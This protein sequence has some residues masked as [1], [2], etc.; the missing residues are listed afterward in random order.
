MIHLQTALCPQPCS[1]PSQ[2]YRRHIIQDQ[3]IP[4]QPAT[5]RQN[6]PA[7]PSTQHHPHISACRDTP[8]PF[9]PAVL[10]NRHQAT[11]LYDSG[12][13]GHLPHTPTHPPVHRN[14]PTTT[15]S[16][17]LRMLHRRLTHSFDA[18]ISRVRLLCYIAQP[19]P[20]QMAVTVTPLHGGTHSLSE[21][22]RLEV[23]F[24]PF[25]FIYLHTS[26][27]DG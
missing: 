26:R 23:K 7:A 14:P 16:L 17:R 8:K 19:I 1:C 15:L 18:Q 5:L 20:Q 27:P 24:A 9:D 2:S 25:H 12:R 6:A 11:R 22:P 21:S 3:R 13:A 10:L 4:L